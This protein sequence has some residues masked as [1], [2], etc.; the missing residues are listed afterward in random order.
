MVRRVC[1]WCGTGLGEKKIAGTPAHPITHGI[2]ESCSIELWG[3]AGTPLEEFLDSLG[4]PTLL[5]DGPGIVRS[6]N[7]GALEMV[8]KSTEEVDGKF[9]GQVFDCVNADLP[10]GCGRTVQCSACTVRNTVTLTHETGESQTRVPAILKVRP[11]GIPEEIAFYITTEKVGD[12]VLV[13]IEP[14]GAPASG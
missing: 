7:Q 2:C 6:A 9:G 10:G 14:A 12:R 1:A 4:I 13:Q 5:V 8:G 3:E 11:R